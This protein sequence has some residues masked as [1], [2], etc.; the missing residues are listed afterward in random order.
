MEEATEDEERV[1]EDASQAKGLEQTK[2]R[3]QEFNLDEF[4]GTYYGVG[5]AWNVARRL[6][7]VRR[8]GGAARAW[9]RL[10]RRRFPAFTTVFRR[11]WFRSQQ[12]AGRVGLFLPVTAGATELI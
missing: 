11:A 10:A 9:S 12:R 7:K 3:Q 2:K 8:P 5:G 1:R 4:F 6:P